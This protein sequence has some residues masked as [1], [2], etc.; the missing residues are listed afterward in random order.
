MHSIDNLNFT[1]PFVSN[2]GTD[3]EVFVVPRFA[4]VFNKTPIELNG[5]TKPFADSLE[6]TLGFSMKGI[7]LA[8]YFDYVPLKTNLRV[9]S[10][11]LDIKA[12][13]TFTRFKDKDPESHVSGDVAVKDLSIMDSA[14]NQV[15]KLPLLQTTIAPSSF[16][17]GKV[18]LAKI[19]LQGPEIGIT[20]DK[21]GKVN[22]YNLMPAEQQAQT[23]PPPA[24]PAQKQPFTLQIDDISL[25]DARVFIT[26]LF[27]AAGSACCSNRSRKAPLVVHYR[28]IR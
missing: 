17:A 16:L 22:I 26:D 13:L 2:I 7:D 14:N 9:A 18:H 24:P 3:V 27:K 23:P 12:E 1:I 19:L 28:H 4:T 21:E 6:T 5:K 11:T 15:L 10:G 20:R 8:Y 25:K